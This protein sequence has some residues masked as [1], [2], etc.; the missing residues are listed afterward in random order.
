MVKTTPTHERSTP[1]TKHI[2]QAPLQLWGLQFNL[3]FG[4]GQISK[5]YQQTLFNPKLRAPT[6][7]CSM[8]QTRAQNFLRDKE[9]ISR[10]ATSNF[11]ASN[12]HSDASAIQGHSQ[13]MLKAL[14]SDTSII[15]YICGNKRKF[16]M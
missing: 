13:G 12:T 3:R 6:A 9:H 7:S 10:T 15:Q 8:G 5:L 11:L 1:M 14:L 4:Q 2:P 16:Y